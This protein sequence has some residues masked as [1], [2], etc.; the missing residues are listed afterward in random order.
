M[1]DPVKE[2]L[3]RSQ[4]SDLVFRLGVCLDEGRFGEMK[5][6]FVEDAS[7]TTPGG[8][9]RGL[10]M[11]IALAE[12]NHR[13]EVATQV[14]STNLL[15]DVQGDRATVRGNL[16]VRAAPRPAA[17][18]PAPAQP[19]LAPTLGFSLGE[20]Y[21][22]ECVR[23]PDGWRFSRVETVPVWMSGERPAPRPPA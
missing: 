22:I 15:V 9:A 2:L 14:V 5:A 4:I 21:R 12:R 11:I 17:D 13:P 6:L 7:A 10:D 16:V 23:A 18:Q 19:A 1:N 8:T 3:D 20:V